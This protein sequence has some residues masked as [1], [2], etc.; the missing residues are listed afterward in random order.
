MLLRQ[1]LI[2]CLLC[3]SILL[4]PG[5][6][7]ARQSLIT[8]TASGKPFIYFDIH[9]Q[10]ELYGSEF[11]DGENWPNMISERTLNAGEL[12][13]LQSASDYWSALWGSTTQNSVPA[14]II[15]GAFY[16][17]TSNAFGVSGVTD[18]G[19]TD[20]SKSLLYGTPPEGDSAA[21]I[22]LGYSEA[23]PDYLGPLT[24][25]PANGSSPHLA[26][27]ISHELG[28]AMGI[29]SL[30]GPD[31]NGD[32]L[33]H[34]EVLSNWEKHLVD[35]FGTRAEVGM[36]TELGTVQKSG[37]FVIDSTGYD[38]D[39]DL[40]GGY[41]YFQGSNTMEALGGAGTVLPDAKN[42]QNIPG[43]PING[44]ERNWGETPA[45]HIEFPELSHIE[46][47]NSMM[48][49]QYYRNW[50]TYMEAELAI[51]QD[52]GI[53]VDRKNFFGQSIYTDNGTH[54][55]TGEQALGFYARNAAGT[56]YMPGVYNT[57]PLAIGLHVYGAGN[58][59]NVSGEALS[60]GYGG[61][62]VRIDGWE[63]DLTLGADT[64]IHALGEGGTGLMIAYGKGHSLTQRGEVLATGP[65]GVGA[66]FD[67]GSNMLGNG[68][69][70]R[71][72]YIRNSVNSDGN[73]VPLSDLDFWN[74]DGSLVTNFDLSGTLMGS[75]AAIYI[76]ENAYV[77][78]INIMRN[79]QLF[80][81]I[82]SDWDP[83]NPDIQHASPGDLTTA[84][85]FGLTPDADGQ[86]TGAADADFR[87]D[88]RGNISG[89]DSLNVTL[90]GGELIYGGTMDVL[91]FK[92]DSNTTL[93]AVPSAEG[94]RI[95]AD[96]IAL[97]SGSKV[98]LFTGGISYGAPL[99]D[100]QNIL[101]L[102]GNI[103]GDM[104]LESIPTGTFIHG[105]Y[106]YTPTGLDWEDN[107]GGTRDLV[108]ESTRVFSRE[109]AG[110]AAITAPTSI[111]TQ[112]RYAQFFHD[113]AAEFFAQASHPEGVAL[114]ATPTYGDS[115]RHGSNHYSIQTPGLA[116]GVDV[117]L[118]TP[119][120]E[121]AFVGMGAYLSWPAYRSD[122]ADIDAESYTGL[123]YGGMRL[124][125]DLELDAF[126]AI[127]KTSY[128]QQRSVHGERYSADYSGNN[129]GAGLS[130]ARS[131]EL[132]TFDH[133][134]NI[135]A[136]PFATYEFMH[137]GVNAYNEGQAGAFGLR[138]GK[139]NSN[140]HRLH[141]G[142]ALSYTLNNNFI[143]G[144]VFYAGLY[145]DRRPEAE[146]SMTR[147]P[148]GYSMIS[149]GWEQDEHAAGLGI[150]F[151]LS[152]SDDARLSGGYAFI[153]GQKTASHQAELKLSVS[154]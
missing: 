115:R 109:R 33:F 37:V 58:T 73:I 125:A 103:T 118:D 87:L 4:A 30:A 31:D 56:A 90:A 38:P 61:V 152:L 116:L 77:E 41:A 83:G 124:L 76:S 55:L 119:G 62:G 97:Q 113:R 148:S 18:D 85:T 132:G 68:D 151:G 154:F 146:V 69:E 80:G 44:F 147:D 94:M 65:G 50:G 12:A 64:R 72:S 89:A 48:S 54:D 14:R 24:V 139:N 134:S 121:D 106:D 9:D 6:A 2:F 130:L 46:L 104:T 26:V 128:E 3:V 136:R 70:Y 71:G 100:L 129:F 7:Q 36:I 10:G 92:A 120:A 82:I 140:L 114:W 88:Y 112:N 8:S 13:A 123:L 102:E 32:I 142:T 11:F 138:V 143:E 137:L 45:E 20:L 39:S 135:A 93:L 47:R 153:G 17:S 144:R 98:G 150:D 105:F 21:R 67:F 27:T 22:E 49:H 51:L 145:G 42:T 111:M 110:E 74:L 40:W 95:N 91:S 59:I 53:P 35:S 29:L 78:N 63:N 25:L 99:A 16:D 28:H 122:A 1:T 84:L 60:A 107:G 66:R 108:L 34:P 131:F 101:H 149:R 75:A 96:T 86:A 127:G 5:P 141:V 19:S 81:D 15:V 57:A 117:P 52:I 133:G 43:V 23:N 126:A 79:A